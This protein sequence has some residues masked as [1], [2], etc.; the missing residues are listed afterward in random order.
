MWDRN[1]GGGHV[2][3]AAK[4]HVRIHL[5]GP[6]GKKLNP[7]MRTVA[8][9]LDSIEQRLVFVHAYCGAISHLSHRYHPKHLV[10]K[11]RDPLINQILA[12]SPNTN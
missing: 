6:S 4:C 5:V 1:G 10:Y 3:V 9:S 12:T 11:F 2:R 8:I 7:M